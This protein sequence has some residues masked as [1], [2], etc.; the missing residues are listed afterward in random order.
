MTFDT[1]T[2]ALSFTTEDEARAFIID[3]KADP[4]P[5]NLARAGVS[6]VVVDP[7][8]RPDLWT[9]KKVATDDLG[10]SVNVLMTQVAEIGQNLGTD[11]ASFLVRLDYVESEI[12]AVRAQVSGATDLTD[13]IADIEARISL[14]EDSI[15]EYSYREP[16]VTPEANP[17]GDGS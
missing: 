3:N 7:T 1:N 4:G 9:G 5:D 14:A 15:L 6:F 10:A 11:L 2:R 17:D 16:T 12:A 13:K 8:P